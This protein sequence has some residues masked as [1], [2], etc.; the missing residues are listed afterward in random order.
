MRRMEREGLVTP[1]RK[2]RGVKGH[3]IY[4]P[5]GLR[6]QHANELE[7]AAAYRRRRAVQWHGGDRWATAYHA[8]AALDSARWMRRHYTGWEPLP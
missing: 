8:S 3:A 2:A 6:G 7:R 1:A 4:V 5:W